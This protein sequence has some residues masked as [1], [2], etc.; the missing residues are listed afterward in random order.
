MAPA[1]QQAVA[2]G[3]SCCRRCRMLRPYGSNTASQRVLEKAG[4]VLE[5]RMQARS[6]KNGRTED[7]LICAMR[8]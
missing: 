3:S 6:S 5:A 8:R 1:I 2:R 4:F 7:E